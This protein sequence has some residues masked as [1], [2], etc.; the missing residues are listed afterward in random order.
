MPGKCIVLLPGFAAALATKPGACRQFRAAAGTFAG[1]QR[2]ATLLA[3][4]CFARIGAAAFGAGIASIAAVR[5]C[6]L[7]IAWIAT[8]ATMFGT[9]VMTTSIAAV[10]AAES[11]AHQVA[12]HP[13]EKSHVILLCN[14]FNDDKN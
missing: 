1:R 13:F 10:V 14:C 3:E 12:Q 8:V 9:A 2:G 11:A 4:A 5:A 7:R 6:A